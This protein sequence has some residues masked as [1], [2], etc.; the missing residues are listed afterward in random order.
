M[1][2]NRRRLEAIE[3]VGIANYSERERTAKCWLERIWNGKTDMSID[4]VSNAL[5]E[6]YERASY[7]AR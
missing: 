7:G 4:Q 5:E 2:Y 3:Y 6:A 1:G